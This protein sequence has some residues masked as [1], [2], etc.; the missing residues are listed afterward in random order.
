MSMAL[1]NNCKQMT[2]NDNHLKKLEAVL[3]E[4]LDTEGIDYIRN[5]SQNHIPGKISLSFKE[6]EGEMILHQKDLKGIYISTG[7]ACD[8][9]NTQVSHVIEAIKVPNEYAEGTVRISFG[10]YNTEKEAI[11]LADALPLLG[12]FQ[13]GM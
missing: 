9:A 5:G 8:S 2:E 10:K 6:C 13:K 7:F 4:Q 12:I 11:A 1:K 3:L